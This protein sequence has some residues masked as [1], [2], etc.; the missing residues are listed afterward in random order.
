MAFLP[1]NH[2]LAIAIMSYN[3]GLNF[4]LLADY[5]ALPDIDV[6]A[7]ALEDSRD[8]LLDAARAKDKAQRGESRSKPARRSRADQVTPA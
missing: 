5:D 8:E 7:Q 6:I 3:G 1:V 2:S 4:G